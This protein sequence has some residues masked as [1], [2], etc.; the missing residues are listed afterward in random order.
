MSVYIKIVEE[1]K[2]NKIKEMFLCSFIFFILE[3]VFKV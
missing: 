2:E 1:E 3:N